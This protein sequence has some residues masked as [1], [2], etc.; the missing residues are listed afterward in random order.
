MLVR[1]Y[2]VP[3]DSAGFVQMITYATNSQ[4]PVELQDLRSNDEI[5]RQ[6]ESLSQLMTVF[7]LEVVRQKE[8]MLR[9]I[10]ATVQATQNVEQG[11]AKL[12]EATS[13]S[14]D[15]RV[16][17]LLFL[18]IMSFTLVFLHWYS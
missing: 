1:L 4:N 3:R 12:V 11:N 8:G 13:T 6:L 7:S 16:M 2:Q 17:V 9:I 10:D 18:V 5:Q 14:V 15:F